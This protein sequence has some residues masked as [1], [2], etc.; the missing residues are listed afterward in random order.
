M[1]APGAPAAAPVCAVSVVYSPEMRYP[2]R[3]RCECGWRI[4]GYVS[5][6]AAD[7]MAAEHLAGR[8]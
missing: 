6:H 1:T 2:Y 3:P 8:I 7:L 4:W 5:R